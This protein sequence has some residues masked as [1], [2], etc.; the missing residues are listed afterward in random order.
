MKMRYNKAEIL[1]EL[2]VLNDRLRARKPPMNGC[3]VQGSLSIFTLKQSTNNK[4][5]L[6]VQLKQG[7]LLIIIS[8]V[9]L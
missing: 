8:A 4:V 1:D 3:H 5:T 7:V 2:T 9:K 6:Y